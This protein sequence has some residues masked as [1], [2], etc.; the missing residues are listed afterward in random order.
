MPTKVCRLRHTQD[1]TTILLRSNLYYVLLI[2]NM[3]SFVFISDWLRQ[4]GPLYVCEGATAHFRWTYDQTIG[5]F[6]V[7]YFSKVRPDWFMLLE[8]HKNRNASIFEQRA[9]VI[10][11][12]TS[13]FRLDETK[14]TD[15][16]TYEIDIY[17]NAADILI[18][19]EAELHVL[20]STGK[21]STNLS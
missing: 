5:E 3:Y 11:K 12:S 19:D 8:M 10:G 9:Y 18:Y 20:L 17:F 21:M 15:S 16:G 7:V 2:D 14:P 6:D 4:P 1:N 13:E